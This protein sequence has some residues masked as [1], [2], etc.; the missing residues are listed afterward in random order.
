MSEPIKD[1][2]LI[3]GTSSSGKSSSLMNL[4]DHSG[5]M[6]LNCE[7]GKRLPF[8]NK[9]DRYVITDP[10]QVYEAFDE[11]ENMPHIHTIVVDSL[12]F[13]MDMF[14]SMYV[15]GSSNTMQGWANYNQYFKNLMQ[16]KVAKSSKRVIFTAHTLAT[17]NENEMVVE[18]KVPVKGALKNQGIEAYFTCIVY[19]KRVPLK[20]LKN[21]ENELLVV[22]EEE[23]MLGFKHVFQTCI[24]KDTVHERIRSPRFMW[25]TNESF[26]DN[27]VMK[28]FK[29]IDE[30]YEE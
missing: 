14:E 16:D 27:D 17:L 8:P 12:T 10:M 3:A 6:Y 26:I 24:T 18:T 7:S 15:I 1:L 22:T 4:P 23:E 5:V 29:R 30:F 9:F 11:A 25:K 19:A 21:Y 2:V 13:L 20:L 28:L